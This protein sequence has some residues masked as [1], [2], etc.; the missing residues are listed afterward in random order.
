MADLRDLDDGREIVIAGM[1]SSIKKSA[2]K[3]PSR[4]G[5]SRYVNFDL[6]YSG[7][8]VRCIMWHDDFASEGEMIDADAIIVVKGRIDARGRCHR[9]RIQVRLV[10][11]RLIAAAFL[12]AEIL[13]QIVRLSDGNRLEQSPKLILISE[14]G[15]LTVLGPVEKTIEG[16]QRDFTL[17]RYGTIDLLHSV[18]DRASQTLVKG[19]PQFLSD[20]GPLEV[21]IRWYIFLIH[22]I[23]C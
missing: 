10:E 23:L 2:T 17:A 22:P 21:E 12:G 8:D 15:E 7:G 4:N 16:A 20:L 5:H 6:E 9:I 11:D 14:L 18:L 1:V 19:F 3:K 13:S